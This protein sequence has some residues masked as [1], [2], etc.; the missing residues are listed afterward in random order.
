MNDKER[1]GREGELRRGRERTQKEEIRGGERKSNELRL[2]NWIKFCPEF[3]Q[4]SEHRSSGYWT[5]PR[6]KIIIIRVMIGQSGLSQLQTV[7]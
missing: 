2:I 6:G 4:S 5:P 7:I 1:R 3:P